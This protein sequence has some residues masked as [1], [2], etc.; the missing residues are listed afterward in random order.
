MVSVQLASE[1]DLETVGASCLVDIFSSVIFLSFFFRSALKLQSRRVRVVGS[2]AA[3]S[4]PMLI[5]QPLL[6]RCAQR[7]KK[8]A[9]SGRAEED[10]L[11]DAGEI[12]RL[13]TAS[14]N[15]EGEVERGRN[16]PIDSQPLS[17]RKG[18]ARRDEGALGGGGGGGGAK[19]FMRRESGH[20]DGLAGGSLGCDWLV[21]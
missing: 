16:G 1:S 13:Q 8:P 18:L 6:S 9:S 5:F 7:P 2:A 20:G 11:V 4:E 10:V 14:L 21:G 12:K 3:D 19:C 17:K 15:M